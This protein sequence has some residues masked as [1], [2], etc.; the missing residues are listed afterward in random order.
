M[1]NASSRTKYY[2]KPE[3]LID[4]VE[5]RLKEKNVYVLSVV[6]LYYL[7]CEKMRSPENY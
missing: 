3:T 6:D 2:S 7:C 5:N 1:K 4:P